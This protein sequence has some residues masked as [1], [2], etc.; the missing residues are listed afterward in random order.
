M[1]KLQLPI[2]MLSALMFSA[3]FV[4]AQ[5]TENATSVYLTNGTK[6]VGIGTTTPGF[7]LDIQRAGNASMSFKST[8]GTANMILDRANNTATASVSYRTNGAPT[9]Q[10]GTVGTDN[11]VIRNVFLGAPAFCVVQ[12]NNYVGVGTNVPSASFSVNNKVLVDAVNGDLS[13]TDQLG[14]ITFPAVL[15]AA[16]AMINLFASGTVNDDRMVIAHSPSYQTWGLQYQDASDKMNFIGAGSPVL[17]ADLANLRVGVGTTSPSAKFHVVGT[18]TLAGA[19]TITSTLNVS[20]L[21]TIGGSLNVNGDT[22]SFGSIERLIDG[23][24]STIATNATLRP[25]NDH[26][27]NL[28]TPTYR[29]NRGY[30]QNLSIG[31][32]N[33]TLPLNVDGG[34]DVGLASGGFACFGTTTGLNIAIDDN[35]I[36]AR[37]NG[38]TSPLYF[39]N[40]GGNTI[41]NA[42][43][44]AVTIGTI[45]PATGYLLSVDGKVIAEEVRVELSGSWPDYVFSPDYKRLSIEEL[46]NHITLNQHL[47]NVPSA[48]EVASEGIMLGQMQTKTMEKVEENALYIIELNNKLKAQDLLIQK[49]LKEVE[50]LKSNR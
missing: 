34:T 23:G 11:F 10:T 36:M 1:K 39:Q 12:A 17:T 21:T 30:I 9:F 14:S 25:E 50:G 2:A 16:D 22:V 28:G 27:T 5:W 38:A 15:G 24:A 35:E 31:G 19:T 32:T 26:G 37:S 8:T 13:L 49:L 6:N 41:L 46:E 18:S 42:N 33:V 3:T 47:P 45:T 48:A 29:W 43:G 7:V 4:N 40:S 20:G 44:G